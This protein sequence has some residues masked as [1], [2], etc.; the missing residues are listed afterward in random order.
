MISAE[1]DFGHSLGLARQTF[2]SNGEAEYLD[3]SNVHVQRMERGVIEIIGECD[4]NS[5][6]GQRRERKSISLPTILTLL[7]RAFWEGVV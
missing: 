1:M 6:R 7:T 3:R 5:R 4:P 2:P